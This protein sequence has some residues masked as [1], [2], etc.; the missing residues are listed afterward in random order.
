MRGNGGRERGGLPDYTIPT[1]PRGLALVIGWNGF[2]I[3]QAGRFHAFGE[4]DAELDTEHES[5]MA[6]PVVANPKFELRFLT[7]AFFECRPIAYFAGNAGMSELLADNLHLRAI[8]R[9]EQHFHIACLKV[10]RDVHSRK[11]GL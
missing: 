6:I 4:P 9:E 7:G 1:V 5:A 3:F 2:E 10:R 11:P 8:S